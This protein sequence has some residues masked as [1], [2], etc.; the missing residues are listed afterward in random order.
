MNFHSCEKQTLKLHCPKIGFTK[1]FDDSKWTKTIEDQAM[2]PTTNK[3]DSR[4]I[5]PYHVHILESFDNPF[6]SR[7]GF[8]YLG[9]SD[10][11]LTF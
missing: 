9:I 10:M 6:I 11:N 7:R 4:P 3:N 1:V 8:I 5:V 2:K